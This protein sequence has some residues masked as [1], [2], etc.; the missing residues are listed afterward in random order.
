[1]NKR[2][3]SG[4]FLIL[5][6]FL[7][8]GKLFSENIQVLDY[9]NQVS[10]TYSTITDYKALISLKTGSQTLSGTIWTKG[11]KVLINWKTGEVIS[12]NDGKLTVYV[13]DNRI[14]LEQDMVGINAGSAEGLSMF[15]KYYKYSYHSLDGYKWVPLDENS[16]E[17]VIKLKFDAKWGGLEFRTMI[18]SF[19]KNNLIRRIEGTTFGGAYMVFDFTNVQIN[20]GIP[21]N[22]FNYKAPG[23]SHSVKNFIYTP[24]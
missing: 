21:D 19:T 4:L 15:R 6:L 13:A 3:K 11:N 1:M 14:I 2:I 24:E 5:F 22:V 23:D 10:S 18:I 7:S 17:Q 20:Q 8:L 16:S 9:F 12:I